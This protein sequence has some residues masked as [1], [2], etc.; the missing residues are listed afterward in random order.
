MAEK[1]LQARRFRSISGNSRIKGGA[2]REGLPE[3][4]DGLDIASV[5]ATIAYAIAS[6]LKIDIFYADD[7]GGGIVLR[8]YRSVTP[9]AIGSHVTTGNQVFRAYLMEGV[10]KSKRIPKW[11]LFRVDRVKSIKIHYSPSRAKWHASYRPNDKHIGSMFV[12]VKRNAR[13]V[14]RRKQ[15]KQNN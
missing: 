11:R 3:E 7:E 14:K 5:R 6:D 13:S 10:S 9:V 12:E 4:Q 8:G 2:R 15:R 1:R